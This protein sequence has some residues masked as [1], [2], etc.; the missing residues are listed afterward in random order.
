MRLNEAAARGLGYQPLAAIAGLDTIDAGELAV[1]I[2][3]AGLARDERGGLMVE[4]GLARAA[5]AEDH[6]P[7][8]ACFPASAVSGSWQ[9]GL[10][11]RQAHWEGA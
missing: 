6:P 4:G 9:M 10:A 11:A 5:T 3:A 2:S 1:R 7:H 8:A